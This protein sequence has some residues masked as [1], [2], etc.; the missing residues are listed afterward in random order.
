MAYKDGSTHHQ[1]RRG[2]RMSH[3]D[4]RLRCPGE[5]GDSEEQ[6]FRHRNPERRLIPGQVPAGLQ[7][8]RVLRAEDPF[9]HGQQRG[10]LVAGPA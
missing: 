9:D 2:K 7:G 5:N 10:V 4:P 3:L 8:V 6:A 1:G